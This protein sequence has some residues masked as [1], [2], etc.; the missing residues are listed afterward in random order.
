M[1]TEVPCLKT[2]NVQS[3]KSFTKS[4]FLN[5]G[6]TMKSTLNFQHTE[7][8][9]NATSTQTTYEFCASKNRDKMLLTWPFTYPFLSKGTIQVYTLHASH[10]PM[11]LYPKECCLASNIIIHMI[12]SPYKLPTYLPTLKCLCTLANMLYKTY[13]TFWMK[14]ECHQ[15]ITTMDVLTETLKPQTQ[16]HSYFLTLWW[17]ILERTTICCINAFHMTCLVLR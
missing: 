10:I 3:L 4:I 8:C 7:D 12:L 2:S 5:S 14:L 9:V 15:P 17:Q 16:T 13:H 1:W 6:R 11:R